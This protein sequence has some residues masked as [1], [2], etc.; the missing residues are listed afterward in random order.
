VRS[1][2]FHEG[3]VPPSARRFGA[4]GRATTRTERKALVE[5]PRTV[6]WWQG[7]S[8][9]AYRFDIQPF[10]MCAAPPPCAYVLVR[11]TAA[12]KPVVVHVGVA[13]SAAPTLNLARIRRIGARHGASE[14][15]S[16]APGLGRVSPGF[17]RSRAT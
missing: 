16:T 4:R 7:A 11:R 2:S 14:S 6:M 17:A 12:Q 13:T 9:R 8:G 5:R 3:H 10:V 15:T 1:S